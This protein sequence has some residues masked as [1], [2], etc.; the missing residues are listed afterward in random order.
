MTASAPF[1]CG[2]VAVLG[3]PNAGKSTLMNALLREKLA[4]TSRR[5][6]TTRSRILGVLTLPEGQILFN[7]TPGVHRGQG[8]FNLAMTEAALAAARDADVRLLLLDAHADWDQPEERIA[9]LEPP[10]LLVRTKVD[11]GP[12]TSVP[13]AERFTDVLEVS[14]EAGLGL[15]RLLERVLELLPESPALYPDDYLTDRSMRF[16]AAEQ[17]REVAFEILRDEVPYALAVEV[18]A[19]K[20]D[21]AALRLRANLLVERESHKGIVVGEGGRML[22]QLGSEARLRLADLVGKPVHLNL[23]VK[24]DRNWSKRLKRARELGYL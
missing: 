14:A 15:A 11:L 2:V 4:I 13:R 8:R 23:W 5:A 3:R 6:Q 10:T 21:D 18:E 17:I 12:P 1:R 24:T 20:E 9:E 7:D 19:W 22:K 16:L